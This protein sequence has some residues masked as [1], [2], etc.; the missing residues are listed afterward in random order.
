MDSIFVVFSLDTIKNDAERPLLELVS[1]SIMNEKKHHVDGTWNEIT[2][3]CMHTIDYDFIKALDEMIDHT[4]FPKVELP[5]PWR[6]KNREDS[7][8]DKLN[9]KTVSK[10]SARKL[11]VGDEGQPSHKNVEQFL[12]EMPKTQTENEYCKNYLLFHKKGKLKEMYFVG[13]S[14]TDKHKIN[15][16]LFDLLKVTKHHLYLYHI[17][18]TID[19]KTRVACRQIWNASRMIHGRLTKYKL[20]DRDM[21]SDWY[22]VIMKQPRH[23]EI[24]EQL[25]DYKKG[26]F[27]NLFT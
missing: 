13:D 10:T 2:G 25:M 23:K 19:G 6:H 22:D 1:G 14:V 8:G 20:G 5:L 15:M 16:E 9:G 12:N 7:S 18:S 21:L 27:S 11:K 4:D 24:A 17:K 26:E 3:S